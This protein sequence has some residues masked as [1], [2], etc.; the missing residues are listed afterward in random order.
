M[1]FS[2]T[3]Y[4]LYKLYKLRGFTARFLVS[5]PL[6][7]VGMLQVVWYCGRVEASP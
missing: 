1:G 4:K 6:P 2:G 5:A 3:R 7:E